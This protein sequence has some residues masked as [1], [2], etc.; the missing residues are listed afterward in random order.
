VRL[1]QVLRDDHLRGDTKMPAV[2]SHVTTDLARDIARLLASGTM[3]QDR[4]VEARDI[5]VLAHRGADLVAAQRALHA[6]G[7]PAVSAGGASVLQS[8]AA[9]DWLALLEAMV[10]PH[11]SV[12]TRAAALTDLLGYDIESIDEVTN[13]GSGEGLDDELARR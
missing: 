9:H 4:P 3:F 13:E 12:L 8:R 5:A 10:A 7:I 2:R 6:L 1:R 11:R